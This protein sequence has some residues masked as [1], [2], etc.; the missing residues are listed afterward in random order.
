MG[1]GG[2]ARGVSVQRRGKH[3]CPSFARTSPAPPAQPP[4]Q[5]HLC[6]SAPGCLLRLPAAPSCP[7]NRAPPLGSLQGRQQ[8]AEAGRQAGVCREAYARGLAGDA[9]HSRHACPRPLTACALAAPDAPTTH[10][11]ASCSRTLPCGVQLG[12]MASLQRT[13][14]PN[15]VLAQYSQLHERSCNDPNNKPLLPRPHPRSPAAARWGGAAACP[16]CGA[17]GCPARRCARRPARK[18]GA[19]QEAPLALYLAGRRSCSG[20]G[21]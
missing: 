4:T 15:R 6:P 14:I 12:S 17:R 11:T 2:Y 8:E 16:R 21:R 10:R 3:A 5:P 1:G 7:R 20:G 13:L 9:Q 19:P 18:R